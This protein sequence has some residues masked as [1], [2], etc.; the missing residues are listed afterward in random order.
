MR[1]K[2]KSYMNNLISIGVAGFR[3]DA[4]KHMWP[5]DLEYIYDG[6]NDLSTTAGF[7]SNTRPF[8]FSEA[9][10]VPLIFL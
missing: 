1:D 7:L 10:A 5:G 8:I 3:V 4:C 6:M 9:S 2:I